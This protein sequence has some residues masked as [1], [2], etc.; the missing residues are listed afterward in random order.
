VP[1]LISASAKGVSPDAYDLWCA[2]A[3]APVALDTDR[4][5]PETGRLLEHAFDVGADAYLARGKRLSAEPSGGL[6]HAAA[7]AVNPSDLG[8][9]LAWS[10]VIE[11]W[12]AAADTVL[13]ICTDPWMFRHLASK[14]GVATIGST[15]A[16][17]PQAAR[18]WLR[19]YLSRLRFAGRAAWAALAFRRHRMRARAGESALLVYAHP[20]S[21]E[22]GK[23]GFF[24]DLLTRLPGLR[25]VL[26]TD[27]PLADVRR[28]TAKDDSI[29]LHAWGNPSRALT[30]PWVKWRPGRTHRA[31]PEGWLVRRAAAREGGGGT[32]AAIRWQHHCQRTWLQCVRPTAVAWPWENHNWEREFVRQARA[33]GVHTVGY[34][35]SV[36]GGQMLNHATGSNADGLDSIPDRIVCNGPQ[37]RAQ[38]EAWGVPGDRLVIGG[39]L[40]YPAP[41]RVRHEADAP[42]FLALPFDAPT[43]A[44]MVEAAMRV[45]GPDRRFAVRAHPIYGF[46]FEETETVRRATG[47]LTEQAAVAGVIYAATTVG[48]E[49][50]LMGLPTLR[51]RPRGR[52]AIDI[53]PKG[54]GAAVA[55]PENFAMALDALEPPPAMAHEDVFAP[56]DMDVWSEL[57]KE[58]E[59]RHGA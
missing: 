29:S 24:G 35:H 7:C 21:T 55:D 41:H 38:L 48:L 31:A 59:G 16:L 49:S 50:L 9:M 18:L 33:F 17:W 34:Q 57:L 4:R 1:V 28:L 56:V 20:A 10:R 22:D 45:A 13:V 27:R 53:L 3:D 43:A 51:F 42:Y 39:A 12:A 2:L 19:G 30:L 32:A 5:M 58:K 47:S 6:S 14:P 40:R 37:T 54:L 44:Q 11:D 23:D 8:L 26:H 46:D 52:I 25:R 36:I 15:P